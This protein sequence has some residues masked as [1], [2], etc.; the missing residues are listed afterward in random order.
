MTEAVIYEPQA[1]NSEDR[2]TK[3]ILVDNTNRP[4]P[5][6]PGGGGWLWAGAGSL[7][8]I[9]IAIVAKVLIFNKRKSSDG[10]EFLKNLRKLKD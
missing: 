7:V 9:G 3:H 5:P 1:R 2:R 6:P 8:V 10:I 4:S